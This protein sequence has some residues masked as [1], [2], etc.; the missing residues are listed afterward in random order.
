MIY[1][2]TVSISPQTFVSATLGS[3]CFALLRFAHPHRASFLTCFYW[4]HL[5]N[6]VN[7]FVLGIFQK[8]EDF[9][10]SFQNSSGASYQLNFQQ[11]FKQMYHLFLYNS[12]GAQRRYFTVKLSV[13][14]QANV[15][16]FFLQIYLANVAR[17]AE[18][19]QKMT[20]TILYHFYEFVVLKVVKRGTK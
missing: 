16:L 1:S 4:K 17:S 20:R 8:L 19:C 7:S 18:A 3:L 15:S 5:A 10:K 11:I 9:Q 13:I 2:W 12:R 14:F 6:A